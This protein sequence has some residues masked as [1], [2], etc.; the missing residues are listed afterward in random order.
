MNPEILNQVPWGAVM[1][2]TPQN[3]L[4][5]A[6]FI[7]FL[8]ALWFVAIEVKRRKDWVPV[9]AMIGGGLSILYEPLGDIL[10][11]VLYPLQGQH[12]WID[13]FGRKIPAFIGLDYFWYMSVPAIYFVRRLEQ[14]TLT[15]ASLWR[16]FFFSLLL[17]TAIEL[18]G[19]NLDAWI[20]YGTQP[21]VFYG[22]PIVWPVTYS[23]FLMTISIGLQLMSTNLDRKHHWVIMFLTPIFMAGG[24]MVLALPT[25]AAMF[26]TSDPFWIYVGGT[27]TIALTLLL[28]H[29]SG[30]V[31]C[32]DS[33]MKVQR[34][35]LAPA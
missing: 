26:T 19:V 27:T 32:V 29:V 15:Q 1:P 34:R 4:D 2:S 13:L 22:V 28:V 8:L 17:A 7:I 23:G 11:S 24:H 10:V 12:T 25:A 18:V 9:Y 16:M 3:V 30:L 35:S 31:Y 5:I 6:V 33:K 14:G 21:F 20:Y